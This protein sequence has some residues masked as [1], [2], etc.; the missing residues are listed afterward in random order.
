MTRQKTML[1]LW[2]HLVLCQ[3]RHF[4]LASKEAMQF[5]HALD[6]VLWEIL[7]ANIA[8]GAV[9]LIK[10][11]ISD[12]FYHVEVAP[13]AIPKLCV[14]APSQPGQSELLIALPLVLPMV[15]KTALTSLA[16]S[17]KQLLM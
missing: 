11:D 13:H 8:Y 5:G 12:G 2:L 14:I 7:L 9:N 10:T 1:D 6:C 17:L 15:R 4:P 3:P 16:W